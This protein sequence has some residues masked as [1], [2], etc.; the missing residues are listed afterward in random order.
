MVLLGLLGPLFAK[1]MKFPGSPD[2][3]EQGAWSQML[4]TD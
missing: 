1:E 3:I 2:Q 4:L